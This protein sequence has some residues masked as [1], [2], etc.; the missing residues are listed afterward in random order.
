MNLKMPIYTY[1]VYIYKYISKL[2]LRDVSP[3]PGY[4]MF[5]LDL[6]H[7]PFNDVILY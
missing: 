5:P 7:F 4:K 2:N 6:R 3:A 1:T